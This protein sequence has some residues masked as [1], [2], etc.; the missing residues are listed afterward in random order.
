[1]DW[2]KNRVSLVVAFAKSNFSTD[3]AKLKKEEDVRKVI[4]RLRQVH[5]YT[6]KSTILYCTSVKWQK[7][8]EFSP[9]TKDDSPRT[10]DVL[11]KTSEVLV[12][13]SVV[14]TKTSVVSS[15]T[16]VVFKKMNPVFTE[17]NEDGMKRKFFFG[18]T[19]IVYCA[20]K[21]VTGTP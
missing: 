18:K 9:K 4:I 14:Y 5:Y 8:T 19:K 20:G 12:K 3:T 7:T 15:T 2:L 17:R 11:T 1:M 10:K 13:T 6:L 16:T 21:P